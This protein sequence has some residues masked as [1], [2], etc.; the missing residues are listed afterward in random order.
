MTT[1]RTVA[2]DEIDH[3]SPVTE[4]LLTALR[5]NPVAITEGASGAPRIVSAALRTSTTTASLAVPESSGRYYITLGPY[6]FMP[7]VGTVASGYT[8]GFGSIASEDADAPVLR[9]ENTS[10][11][12]AT[13]NVAWRRIDA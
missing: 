4:T 9:I 12:G 3:Q 11:T 2:A 8:V 6:A 10:G 7:A 5:D 1:Y 13:V